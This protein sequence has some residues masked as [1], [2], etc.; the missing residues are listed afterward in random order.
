MCLQHTG[1]FNN[2]IIQVTRRAYNKQVHSTMTY[3]S[4]RDV[5]TTHR[6]T[7]RHR[8]GN[9]MCLPHTGT[10]NNDMV[11]LKRHAYNTQVH[12]S[13]TA[14]AVVDVIITWEATIN[15]HIQTY[16]RHKHIVIITN[17][18]I[19][20]YKN[21]LLHFLDQLGE[22]YTNYND[23]FTAAFRNELLTKLQLKTYHLAS[24]LLLHYL[25]KFECTTAQLYSKLIQF[26]WC[27][28]VQLQ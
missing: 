5:P 22:M 18:H 26:K 16:L 23:P 25:V 24:K 3:N 19:R 12:K 8:T 11:Q 6:H 21:A 4:W 10:L 1:T 20:S 13:P 9:K 2:D 14:A 28:T 7:Q 27:K 17:I 15:I